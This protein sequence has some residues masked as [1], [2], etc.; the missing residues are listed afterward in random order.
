MYIV[1]YKDDNNTFDWQ[2][3]E[4]LIDQGVA[5]TDTEE[6]VGIYT[7]L[8]DYVMNTQTILPLYHSAVGIAWSDRID[9][10]AVNPTYYHLTD[11]SW[12]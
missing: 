5:V 9:V 8:W 12:A 6:R 11:M 4:D 1:S 2:Y 7:E 10:S 3:M